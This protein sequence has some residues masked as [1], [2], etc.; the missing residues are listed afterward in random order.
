MA[1]VVVVVGRGAVSLGDNSKENLP[2]IYVKKG[3]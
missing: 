3:E 1:L 2:L